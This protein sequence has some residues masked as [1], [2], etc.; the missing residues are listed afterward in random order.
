MMLRIFI[1]WP[2]GMIQLN[3]FNVAYGTLIQHPKNGHKKKEP[4]ILTKLPM[5]TLQKEILSMK[6][7]RLCC[8]I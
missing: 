7:R 5:E 8:G 3:R 4:M 6:I 1:S 2:N